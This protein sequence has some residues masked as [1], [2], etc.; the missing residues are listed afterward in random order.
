M[1]AQRV[2]GPV[3]PDRYS[4]E[5]ERLHLEL[6]SFNRRIEEIE[7]L[8]SQRLTVENL[9][10]SSLALARQIDVLRSSVATDRLSRSLTQQQGE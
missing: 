7:S 6:A 10:A 3:G 1:R 5:I 9:K 8:Q 4:A 2:W